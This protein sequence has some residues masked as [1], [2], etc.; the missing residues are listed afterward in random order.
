MRVPRLILIEQTLRLGWPG[1]VGGALLLAALGYAVLGLLPARQALASL[2]RQLVA[3]RG[4]LAAAATP[5]ASRPASGASSAQLEDFRRNL[6]AQLDATG[7]IDRIYALA[8]EEGI[9][10]ARGEYALG[11]D[12]KTRLARYQVLLPVRGSYPQLRRF[13]H[14]LQTQLPALA[15]E[16]VE[17]QRKQIADSALEGR[18]RMTLYLAR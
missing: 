16:E 4:Q 15:L 11:L 9:S 6:P 17:L 3:D 5:A 13:L 2:E 1:L 10:L 14:G 8:G 7:A 18:I 12:P